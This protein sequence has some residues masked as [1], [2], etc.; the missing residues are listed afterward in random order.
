MGR[1]ETRVAEPQPNLELPVVP[2]PILVGISIDAPLLFADERHETDVRFKAALILMSTAE[3]TNYHD[4]LNKP[5]TVI[6]V[7][8][9]F[10]FMVPPDPAPNLGQFQRSPRL[11]RVMAFRRQR[12]HPSIRGW[13]GVR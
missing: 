4:G 12:I 13:Q 10:P 1:L 9:S 6:M 3:E 7:R 11:R 5:A 2:K 8:W